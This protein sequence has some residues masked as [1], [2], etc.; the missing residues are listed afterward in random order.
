MTTNRIPKSQ[1]AF[2]MALGRVQ[3]F[4]MFRAENAPGPLQEMETI[5]HLRAVLWCAMRSNI[6][7]IQ[8]KQK[9]ILSLIGAKLSSANF[10]QTKLY[11][12]NLTI[13]RLFYC[14]QLT[15]CK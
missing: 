11:E 9:Q 14:L 8:D 2:Q 1:M 4:K 12:Q 10:F 15:K 13:L 5:D 6:Q 7:K 3:I